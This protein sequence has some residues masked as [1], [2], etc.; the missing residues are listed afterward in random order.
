MENRQ[1]FDI[2]QI[3]VENVITSKENIKIKGLR[4]LQQRKYRKKEQ[5]Y[6]L[7]GFHLVEEAHFAKHQLL[8]IYLTEKFQLH[9]PKWLMEY[10]CYVVSEE[11]MAFFST[12]PTPQG[13]VAVARFLQPEIPSFL[14]GGYLLLDGIQD[15]GNLGTMI[16]T[17]DA[18]GLKGVVLSKGS[19]DLYQGKV[20]RAL[21]GSQYHL[22]VYVDQELTFWIQ[23]AK[24][25]N[26]IVYGTEL[27]K[28]AKPLSTQSFTQDFLIVLG[29]EGQGVSKDILSQTDTNLYIPILGQAESLNVGVATGIVLYALTKTS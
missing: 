5:R 26:I 10:D 4:K 16:R 9:A 22:P 14:K 3:E 21:Q 17:A 29:N 11:V 20:L 15:P 18:F 19:T 7:E 23:K 24:Q 13:I 25:E 1:L 6:V 2:M 12:L 27:N 8:E 28:E